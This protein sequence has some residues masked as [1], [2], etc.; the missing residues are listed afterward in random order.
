M[1]LEPYVQQ[2]VA[3]L[4]LGHAR[5]VLAKLPDESV[6]C[7]VTSPPYFGQRDYGVA[8]QLGLESTPAEYVQ[9]LCMILAEVHRVLAADG[10]LWLNLGDSYDMRLPDLN[11]HGSAAR[12]R[13]CPGSSTGRG[14]A[15]SDRW[16]SPQ[17]PGL[18]LVGAR[19]RVTR[20]VLAI[21]LAQAEGSIGPDGI[22]PAAEARY[23]ELVDAARDLVQADDIFRAALARRLQEVNRPVP[24]PGGEGD[25]AAGVVAGEGETG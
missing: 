7:C 18:L 15:V 21:Q 24:G 5:D 23:K 13:C 1:G 3:T 8:G 19:M 6:N 16:L 17:G 4:Y 2:G 14:E 9:S 20:A 11:R 10:T 12:S 22:G 25:T